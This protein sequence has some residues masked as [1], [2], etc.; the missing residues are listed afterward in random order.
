MQHVTTDP[1]LDMYTRYPI[2]LVDQGSVEC[3]VCPILLHM[4]DGEESNPQKF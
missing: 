2:R 4:N 1:T 3:E